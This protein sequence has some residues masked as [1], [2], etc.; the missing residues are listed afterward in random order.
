MDWQDGRTAK[1]ASVGAGG[2]EA[3]VRQV[4]TLVRNPDGTYT[5]R[6]CNA[7]T[8]GFSAT[9]Q[10]TSIADA[11]ATRPRCS[12]RRANCRR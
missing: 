5:F 12:T 2:F 6:R 10:L 9:G 4:A 8:M 3:P 11:T 7:L 1:A